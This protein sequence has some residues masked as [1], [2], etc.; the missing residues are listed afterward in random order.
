MT[1]SNMRRIRVELLELGE[2]G[3]PSAPGKICREIRATTNGEV[4]RAMICVIDGSTIDSTDCGFQDQNILREF[5]GDGYPPQSRRGAETNE[6]L[7]LAIEVA[8]RS[9]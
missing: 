6:V 5:D 9:A 4:S 7:K 1:S 8:N 3:L 2:I